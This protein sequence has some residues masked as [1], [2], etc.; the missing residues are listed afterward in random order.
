M[1]QPT[2]VSSYT[3]EQLLVAVQ[4]GDSDARCAVFDRLKRLVQAMVSRQYPSLA[5]RQPDFVE[6][7]TSQ[8]FILLLD[9][10]ITRFNPERGRCS[11]YLFGLVRNALRTIIRERRAICTDLDNRQCFEPADAARA[12]GVVYHNR[13][14]RSRAAVD[15]LA[16]SERMRIIF[17]GEDP[18]T[19]ALV[20]SHYLGGNSIS[21]IAE[22]IGANRST[23]SRRISVFLTGA[24]RRLA[25]VGA[26]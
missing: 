12:A 7:V 22:Q 20:S 16:V 8:T 13:L 21:G 24:Y 17:P 14:R 1:P 10:T 2:H 6:D 5:A 9:T 3:D 23:T 26:A 18:E 19:E 4:S 25:S 11:A 15:P